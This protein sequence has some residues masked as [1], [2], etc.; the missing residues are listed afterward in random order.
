MQQQA[1]K[2]KE[3]ILHWT[4]TK[5]MTLSP[6]INLLSTLLDCCGWEDDDNFCVGSI[7]MVEPSLMMQQLVI[8]GSKFLLLVK[9]SWPRLDLKNGFG[10]YPVMRSSTFTVHTSMFAADFF[11]ANCA[12]KHQSQ[13]FSECS[14]WVCHSDN[15]ING[16]DL[17]VTCFTCLV[18][19]LC[20]WFGTMAICNLT[21]NLVVH[22]NAK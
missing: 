17:H 9:L 21:Y 4:S 18:W 3:G 1:I 6:W 5:L 2:E 20:W 7:F 19:I 16:K 11:Q 14:S 12:K 15:H 22:Q 8:S 13:I 10:T